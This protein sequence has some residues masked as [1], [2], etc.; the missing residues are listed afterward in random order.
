MKINYKINNNNKNDTD[1]S[2]L[3]NNRNRNSHKKVHISNFSVHHPKKTPQLLTQF[4]SFFLRNLP[5]LYENT[6]MDLYTILNLRLERVRSNLI[7]IIKKLQMLYTTSYLRKLDLNN[8]WKRSER[9]L[10]ILHDRF[11]SHQW[12]LLLLLFHCSGID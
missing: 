9:Q 12:I 3:L 7:V 4:F 10:N 11:Q 8:L 2:Y 5:Q 6:E 1:K